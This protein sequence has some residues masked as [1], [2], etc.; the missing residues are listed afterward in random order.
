MKYGDVDLPCAD[1][2]APATCHGRYPRDGDPRPAYACDDCCGHGGEGG[3]CVQ[4][5]QGYA[6]LYALVRHSPALHAALTLFER[7]D[8]DLHDA[9]TYAWHHLIGTDQPPFTFP[10][11]RH[12]IDHAVFAVTLAAYRLGFVA[13]GAHVLERQPPPPIVFPACPRCTDSFRA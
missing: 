12:N 7:G 6:A 5:P 11:D 9:L 8:A 2:C 3:A 13:G 1:C 4:L 10:A